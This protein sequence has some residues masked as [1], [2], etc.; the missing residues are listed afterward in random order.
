MH[1]TQVG[2]CLIFDRAVDAEEV[3][4]TAVEIARTIAGDAPLAAAAARKLLRACDDLTET[5]ALA[6]E[7]DACA[8][9][10]QSEDAAEGS[11]AI[12]VER[13]PLFA[14]R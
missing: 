13:R 2:N 10:M 5:E 11:R 7:V 14:G 8:R 9:S 12:Y 4:P 1:I 6:G 3:L